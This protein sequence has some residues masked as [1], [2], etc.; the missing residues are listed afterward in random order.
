MSKDSET[1]FYAPKISDLAYVSS[2]VALASIAATVGI[3]HRSLW[4]D[5]LL[6]FYYAR[7]EVPLDV[8]VSTW[9][10]STHLPTYYA[11]L[12]GWNLIFGESQISS[13]LLSVLGL[14]LV[15]CLIYPYRTLMS[16]LHFRVFAAM[17]LLSPVTVYY[18]SEARM[19]IF[20]IAA[21]AAVF[22]FSFRIA[23]DTAIERPR[24]IGLFAVA[25][26]TLSSIDYFGFVFSVSAIVTVLLWR[27]STHRTIDRPLVLLLLAVAIVP[28][29]WTWF[30]WTELGGQTGGRA[31]LRF[32]PLAPVVAFIRR[33]FEGNIL[34]FV[35]A[36]AGF[37][38]AFRQMAK[39]PLVVFSIAIILLDFLILLAFSLHTPVLAFRTF[40][41]LVV[42][43]IVLISAGIEAAMS[44]A[45]QSLP[46]W[47]ALTVL[48]VAVLIAVTFARGAH[49]AYLSTESW[50]EASQ[51]MADAGCAEAEII[52]D[53]DGADV[54]GTKG[55]F[56][57]EYYFL[58]E[59]RVPSPR[60]VPYKQGRELAHATPRSCPVKA[61]IARSRLN[62]EKVWR[63]VQ[64]GEGGSPGY[65][66]IRYTKT[67]LLVVSSER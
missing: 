60:F 26:L 23:S 59:L 17:L 5:E 64:A 66:I 45:M 38:F 9:K 32:H 24:S 51:F 27:Y 52:T 46:R 40:I 4:L 41:V 63:A 12:R 8:A 29:V 33:L 1:A 10:G 21:S 2:L 20:L 31:W 28:V 7:P 44:A 11:V 22:Y 67:Y 53:I 3:F 6:S 49:A 30:A 39:M 55:A 34:L 50:K 62:P 57:A 65:R 61:F 36:V 47:K 14:P 54:P 15:A 35:V 48:L 16:P 18:A 56:L 13:R 42:P 19:Y 43:A 25:A 37:A 58:R